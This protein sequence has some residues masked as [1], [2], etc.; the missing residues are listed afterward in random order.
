MRAVKSRTLG[1]ASSTEVARAISLS[2]SRVDITVT[3]EL[4][5][6]RWH[7]DQLA[8]AYAGVIDDADPNTGTLADRTH[9][10]ALGSRRWIGNTP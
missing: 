5:A 9:S 2:S 3:G 7:G 4:G 6:K 1:F 10:A 8:R